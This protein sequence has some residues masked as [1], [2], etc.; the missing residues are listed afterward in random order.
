[1][2][3]LLRAHYTGDHK[4]F[5]DMA[6][7]IISAFHITSPDRAN[8]CRKWIEADRKNAKTLKPIPTSTPSVL[9]QVASTVK[10]SD[11]QLTDDVRESLLQVIAEQEA[12]ERL[13]EK[14]LFP[15]NKLLLVGP[16]GCG[17]TMTASAI[18]AELDLPLLSLQLSEVVDSLMG[19]TSKTLSSVFK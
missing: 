13:R 4:H 19:E 9:Q 6:A 8:E 1:M 7:Q 18:A 5:N 11:V 17:K 3:A 14:M 15:V 12:C 16:S 2:V 10:L